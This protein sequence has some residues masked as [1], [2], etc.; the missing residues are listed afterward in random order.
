M[1]VP[2]HR[3]CALIIL[4]PNW[5]S[6]SSWKVSTLF[7]KK[8][9]HQWLQLY[10][11]HSLLLTKKNVHIIYIMYLCAIILFFNLSLY[12]STTY[13]TFFII[14]SFYENVIQ[15]LTGF[16]SNSFRSF[17]R[18]NTMKLHAIQTRTYTH[19]HTPLRYHQ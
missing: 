1:N 14:I 6:R 11:C 3:A 9:P 18:F 8:F 10:P 16:S 2:Q 7:L 19:A 13:V 12:K 15:C 4:I 17:S 5:C